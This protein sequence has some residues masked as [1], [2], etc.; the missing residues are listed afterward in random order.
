GAD[1]KLRDDMLKSTPLGWACRWGQV[2]L[3]RLYLS[4][5]ATVLETDAEPWASPIAWA[6]KMN[7][8]AIISLLEGGLDPRQ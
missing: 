1:L 6:R 8:R 3:V 4:R 2:E 5:G 7:H